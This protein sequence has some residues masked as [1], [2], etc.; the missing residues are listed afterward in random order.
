MI[1]AVVLYCTITPSKKTMMIS[2]LL[3]DKL[4]LTSR[5]LLKYA[6]EFPR[7]MESAHTTTLVARAGKVISP[8][9]NRGKEVRI[10]T[11]EPG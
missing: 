5:W 2:V 1:R 6:V 7:D 11:P 10:P 9:S 8:D 3:K 4:S